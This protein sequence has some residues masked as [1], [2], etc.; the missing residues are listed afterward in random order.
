[1]IRGSELS[2]CSCAMEG[3]GLVAS[4]GQR[5]SHTECL[6]CMVGSGNACSV[7]PKPSPLAAQEIRAEVHTVRRHWRL[8]LHERSQGPPPVHKFYHSKDLRKHKFVSVTVFLLMKNIFRHGHEKKNL[9]N[10]MQ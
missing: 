6:S 7:G 1:M 9:Q 10:G 5:R 2:V 4:P 3:L 8:P